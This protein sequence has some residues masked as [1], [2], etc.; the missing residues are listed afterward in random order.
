MDDEQ[1]WGDP[2]VE[3]AARHVL[4]NGLASG[5]SA[6]DIAEPAWSP[7]AAA[8]LRHRIIDKADEGSGSFMV[9]LKAQLEGASRATVLLCAELLFLQAVPLT[10]LKPDTKRRRIEEVLGWAERPPALPADLDEALGQPGV[11][12]GGVGFLIQIWNQVGWLLSF[13]AHWW[14]Q[15]EEVRQAALDEPWRF[16]EVVAAM[17]IDQPGIRNALLYLA[18]PRTFFPIANQD[19]KRWIREAFL[20]EIG[21]S[22]GR[23]AVSLDRDLLKIRIRQN[24]KA[25]TPVDYYNEPYRSQWQR[26]RDEGRRAWLVRPRPTGAGER[27]QEDGLVSIPATHLALPE[28][29]TG[30]AEIRTAVE[31]A[32]R[33]ENY[34]ERLE[35]VTEFDIFCNRMKVDDLIVTYEHGVLHVGQITGE[36]IA[37]EVHG[38]VFARTVAWSPKIVTEVRRDL[39]ASASR[40]GTIIDLTSFEAHLLD[41]VEGAADDPAPASGAGTAP[42]LDA[43]KAAARLAEDVLYDPGWI[44]ELVEVLA[45]RQQ[46]VLHGPP[47]TGKTFLARKLA[48]H[49]AEVDAIRLVQF[50]PSYS[51][52]DFVEGF[53]PIESPD[54]GVAFTLTPGP[55][56]RL[57]VDAR[58]NPGGAHFLIIDEINR[59]NLAKIFGELYFLLEYREEAIHLQYSPDEPFTLPENVFVIATMNTADRSIA[60]VDAAMRRRF[61]FFELHPDTDPVS[62]LL[63]RWQKATGR[64]RDDREALLTALN[65]EIEDR[66]HRI[67]PSYLMT[68]GADRPGGLERIWEHSILPLLEEHYYGTLDRRQVRERFGLA[69]IRANAAETP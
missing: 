35:L 58:K 32:Y 29:G 9:K 24:E 57:A 64:D 20:H 11:F 10:N 6:L 43:E 60:L 63:A 46:I 22:A 66:D 21:E 69:A 16:R 54:G 39:V 53:R 50:H 62:G 42:L 34:V 19:H 3:R 33:H 18:F 27:W 1:A 2:V 59:G 17:P 40:P 56:R 37:S 61:A 8:D 65:G 26:H 7:E 41:L 67:G 49:L 47:G 51:Y 36:T 52:E 15:P 25:G 14:E 38:G 45:E 68:P 31:E 23:D 30:K 5:L 13:L 4:R 44:T 28:R 55:L 12:N 48:E